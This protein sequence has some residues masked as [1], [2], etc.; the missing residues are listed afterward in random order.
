MED[1]A[2]S[3]RDSVIN[4][5]WDDWRMNRLTVAECQATIEAANAAYDEVFD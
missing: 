2:A 1:Y 5:A 3:H 4:R